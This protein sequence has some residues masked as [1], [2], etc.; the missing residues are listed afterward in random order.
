[1]SIEE[2]LKN[3]PLFK[4]LP[5]Q[6]FSDL[7]SKGV[8]VDI[9]ANQVACREG[10]IADGMYVI[11]EGRVRIFKDDRDGNE[12]DLAT[13]EAGEFFGEVALIDNKP[14]SA[15]VLCLAP[16][17]LFRLG[18]AAFL[19]LMI[20]SGSHEMLAH[21]LSS[22]TEK[23]RD[24][25]E[26]FFTQ[27]LNRRMLR[28]RMEI[29][30]H[31]SLTQMVAGVAHELN[32]PLGIV[33]MAVN[34]IEN[35]VKSHEIADIVNSDENSRE[36]LRDM[37]EATDLA[38]RN[39]ARSRRLVRNFKKISVSQLTDTRET[40]DLP[41]LIGDIIDLFKINARTAK[42]R[43]RVHDTLTDRSW[44]GYP[45]YLTQVFMNIFANIQNYAYEE[46]EGGKIE[47]DI[48]HDDG[49]NPP[50][51]EIKVRDFGKGIASDDLPKIFEPFFTTN[52]SKGGAGLGL[53]IARNIVTEALDGTIEMASVLGEGTLCILTFPKSVRDRM[54]SQMTRNPVDRSERMIPC[55]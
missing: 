7:A 48:K 46:G 42:L 3:I 13:M 10:D 17:R 35:R 36:I 44:T 41:E 28:A 9:E 25:S 40:V 12:V 14:R 45:G 37:L 16:C 19:S 32:T 20:E 24:T 18:Q 2:T 43:I 21:M 6:W 22:L 49:K 52:R 23:I 55:G 33:N 4:H 50:A 30:R 8:I 51:F 53:A 15:T 54:S 34:M 5:D 39:I 27:E 29:E 47:V 38:R 31:R 26:E 1:M 11:L